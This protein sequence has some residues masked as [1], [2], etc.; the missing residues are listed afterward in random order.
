MIPN[1][2]ERME[3]AM[4]QFTKLLDDLIWT[5][6]VNQ[7]VS[8]KH[9]AEDYQL[10]SVPKAMPN[11]AN[12]L[13]TRDN[14]KVLIDSAQGGKCVACVLDGKE[15]RK[16]ELEQALECITPMPEYSETLCPYNMARWEE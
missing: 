4:E 2:P 12:V 9:T 10:R 15:C 11:P 6:P 7:C 5:V 8:L 14:V 16:C 13:M 3:S 1:G